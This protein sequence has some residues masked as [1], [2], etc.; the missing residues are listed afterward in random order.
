M[1]LP[2][3]PVV[4]V[5]QGLLRGNCTHT[6]VCEFLKIPYAAPPIGK[7]RWKP[8]EQPPS[9]EGVLNATTLGP[10]CLQVLD[11]SAP[12][13]GLEDCLFLNVWTTRRCIN[14]G[15]CAI[16][17]WIHGGGYMI[18]SGINYD[19]A[20]NAALAQDVIIVTTNYRLS[21]LGYAAVPVLKGESTG[22]FGLL[23][24]RAAMHWLRSNAA[25]FGGDG[26]RIT[27]AGESAGATSVTCHL[28]APGSWPFFSGAAMESGAFAY[29]AARPLAQARTQYEQLL[30]AT[31]CAHLG[32]LRAADATRVISI[33][34]NR[35]LGFAGLRGKEY[36]TTWAPT[37]DGVVLSG[38]P[39]ALLEAG[40]CA[41]GKPALLGVN[42]DEGTSS[43]G[44]PDEPLL[45]KGFNMTAADVTAFYASWLRH[46]DLV[47]EAL[48]LYYLNTT[49]MET[50]SDGGSSTPASA[51]T[52]DARPY[53]AATHFVGDLLFTCPARRAARHYA[54]HAPAAPP[55]TDEE[56][57]A[58]AYPLPLAPLLPPRAVFS[59]FFDHPPRN[60]PFVAGAVGFHGSAGVSHAYEMQF[61]WQGLPQPLWD[62]AGTLVGSDEVLLAK[63][64]A[65][66]WTN[67]A[68][69]GDPN[70]GGRTSA[71]VAWPRA[72]SAKELAA[73]QLDVPKL[74][75]AVG[76][77]GRRCDFIDRLGPIPYP[78]YKYGS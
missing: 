10:T 16:L 49:N 60:P 25:A 32:C 43:V 18:G 69:T 61:V 63:T 38:L 45:E 52:D 14:A 19:G 68:R 9:W 21:A 40:G 54:F 47:R 39:H 48:H 5:E 22:N 71:T 57:A 64:V 15:G 74:S 4:R 72:G 24:Q 8:P 65:T 58:G 53:W 46:P 73:L 62:G 28:C 1:L 36:A 34:S 3:T 11:P 31:G 6:D 13:S 7:L 51:A 2:P 35:S 37:V 17:L 76:R 44:A 26:R 20:A 70:V 29:W 33:A 59:Y 12:P 23:D 41:H 78:A 67:F 77:N 55:R 27:I 42:R 50:T 66:Y 75:V 30:N 56:E